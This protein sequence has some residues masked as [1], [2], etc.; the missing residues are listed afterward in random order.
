MFNYVFYFCSYS[1]SFISFEFL[2]D[3]IRFQIPDTFYKRN[4]CTARSLQLMLINS[5]KPNPAYS[6]AIYKYRKHE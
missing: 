6:K 5:A 1:T 4:T 2:F 3:F